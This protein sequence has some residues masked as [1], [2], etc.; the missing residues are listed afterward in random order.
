ML[1]TIQRRSEDCSLFPSFLKRYARSHETKRFDMK[2]VLG[3]PTCFLSDEQ[4]MQQLDA[5]AKWQHVAS[6]GFGNV[7]L[8]EWLGTPCIVKWC[9][10]IEQEDEF[11]AFEEFIMSSSLRHPHTVT[12]F[13]ASP[14][15]IVMER[16]RG[17]SLSMKIRTMPTVPSEQQRLTWCL[18][19][20]SGVR[21]IHTFDVIHGDIAV[22]NVM[23]TT[24]EIAKIGD[25]GAA[26]FNKKSQADRITTD[27]YLPLVLQSSS[28]DIQSAIGFD[29]DRYALSCVMLNLLCWNSD[30]YDIC[31]LA[32][33]ERTLMTCADRDAYITDCLGIAC[34]KVWDALLSV[35]AMSTG[36]R[37]LIFSFFVWPC[38][39]M[40]DDNTRQYV[41][42]RLQQQ[43]VSTETAMTQLQRSLGRDVEK[44]SALV[45]VEI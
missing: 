8:A 20:V 35:Q 28:A 24:D 29:T 43:V 6:G 31:G 1:K 27:K 38:M 5:P 14:S 30:I 11:A 25:F 7:F 2:T 34:P 41:Q 32:F 22:D 36:T 10:Q 21:Y 16:M 44:S 33:F 12:F 15:A 19:I 45:A 9:D 42:E 23:F 39:D 26:Y 4:L 3:R 17:G 13:V 18:H 37:C 40:M